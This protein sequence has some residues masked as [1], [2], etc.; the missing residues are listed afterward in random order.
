MGRAIAIGVTL[1]LIVAIIAF[2]I[3]R[4]VRE[5]NKVG[6]LT[7]KQEREMQVLL[8]EAAQVLHGIGPTYDINHTDILSDRSREAVDAWLKKFNTHLNREKELSA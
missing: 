8:H 6:D 1:V 3:I 7:R 2:V 4:S 5:A